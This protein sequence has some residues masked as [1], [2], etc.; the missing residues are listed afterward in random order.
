MDLFLNNVPEDL[1]DTSL[2]K[3]LTPHLKELDVSNWSCQKR[4]K[5]KTATISFLRKEDAERFLHKH[6]H[7]ERLGT[8]DA[9]GRTKAT[10]RLQLLNRPVYC[11]RSRFP[12]DPLMLQSLQSE[13]EKRRQRPKETAKHYPREHKTVFSMSKLLCGFYGYARPLVPSK[14]QQ[15]LLAFSPVIRWSTPQGLAKFLQNHLLITYNDDQVGRSMRVEIPYRIIDSLVSHVNTITVT[16]WEPPRFFSVQNRPTELGEMMKGLSLA[17]RAG[18][19]TEKATRTR[20]TQLPSRNDM[21]KIV[22]GQALVYQLELDHADFSAKLDK[23]RRRDKFEITPYFFPRTRELPYLP[24]GLSSFHKALHR[25][26]GSVPFEIRFQLH[27]LVT[28]NYLLPWIVEGLLNKIIETRVEN[29]PQQVSSAVLKKLLAQQPFPGPHSEASTFEVEEIWRFLQEKKGNTQQELD[30]E[31]LD[32]RARQNLCSIYKA[33]V[34]P[35]NI[36]FW[37]PEPEAKNRILRRFPN[38][39]EYFLRVTFCEE[40]GQDY[41]FSPGVSNHEVEKRFKDIF[42]KG[43]VIADRIY[44]FL[45]FS[46]SSLR[47]HSAWF[48]SPF[49]YEGT[50]HNNFTVIDALGSFHDIRSPA[51]CAARIGQAFSETPFAI[52]MGLHGIREFNCPDITVHTGSLTRVFSDGVG[53]ISYRALH[54][55]RSAVTDKKTHFTCVQI[56]YG[57]FKGMLALDATLAGSVIVVRD[58]MKKFESDDKVNLEIC[59]V[60]NKPIPLYLNR[61]MIKLLEDMGV[62]KRFFFGH[63][64]RELRRLRLITAHTVN[65]IEFLRRQKV[66]DHVGFPQ[67][68]R[69]LELAGIDYKRDRFLC[70]VVEASVLRVL[71]LLKYKARIPIDTGVTLFGVVDEFSF[72]REGEVYV[73]F[74]KSS[75]VHD[76]HLD[77]NHRHVFVTRS[78][79]L[80]PGDIQRAINRVPPLGH[81][82]RSLRNCVIFSS[83]GRRDLPSQLSGGD[84]DGDIYHIIW[85][86]IAVRSHGSTFVPADYPRVPPLDIGR[87]VE[88]QDMSDFFVKFMA[89]D[90]LGMISTK[91]VILAD[92]RPMGTLDHD[93]ILLAE[94]ASTAVDYSKTGV[95]VDLGQLRKIKMTKLRPDFLAPVPP[96][97]ILKQTEICFDAE[98]YTDD[99]D[100]D[101]EDLGPKRYAYYES[102]KVLGHLYRAI[103]E[104]KIWHEDVHIDRRKQQ[105]IGVWDS[106]IRYAQKIS[107]SYSVGE[108]HWRKFVDDAWDIRDYYEDGVSN[109]TYDYSESA[110]MPITELEV[111]TGSIFNKTGSQTRR[112]RD[113]SIQLKDEFQRI[114]VTTA[115]MMRKQKVTDVLDEAEGDDNDDTASSVRGGTGRTTVSLSGLEL[116]LACLQVACSEEPRDNKAGAKAAWGGRQAGAE[117]YSFKVVA[118][119]CLMKELKA[120][121]TLAQSLY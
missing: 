12:I 116:S 114:A 63:Q 33:Q 20:L 30:Q 38:H 31:L 75:F 11:E 82:L 118:A 68:I 24:E 93:C 52:P 108:I 106:L 28:N 101:D 74:D 8:Q 92:Q 14:N 66:A 13:R 34:T 86:D 51:R 110:S 40:D 4:R 19:A 47:S 69:Q 78:P 49:F 55:I 48:M 90:Q 99:Q 107:R 96:T 2:A 41:Y 9:K 109:L 72:L 6:G 17:G 80:H 113:R 16:L 5:G 1:N 65:T 94:M 29:N 21:H 50:L 120:A 103:D 97:R 35:T 119:C 26:C 60:G 62:P 36:S 115:A 15:N 71:R 54:A 85:D 104:T 37:G 105:G 43:I 102:Q 27:A 100:D 95:P 88:K 64:D 42:D 3:H 45:G 44:R 18:S 73:T 83:Q 57:G 59:D 56:R 81:P 111:F 46:H 23:L 70:S 32:E 112:Q 98:M 89:T 121:L 61:Q 77:L 25:A 10:A 67:L 58:S 76:N 53:Q 117:L 87:K 22:M 79:T 39:T 7:V 84:L 91:H